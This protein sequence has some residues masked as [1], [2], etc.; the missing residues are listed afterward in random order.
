MQARFQRATG[1]NGNQDRESQH[2]WIEA[3]IGQTGIPWISM[4]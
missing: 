2:P 3:G 1:Q 4:A